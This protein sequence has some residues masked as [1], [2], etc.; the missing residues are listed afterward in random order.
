MKI[1]ITEVKCKEMEIPLF[2]K[3]ADRTDCYVMLLEKSFIMVEDRPLTNESFVFPKIEVMDIY[4]LSVYCS[5][6]VI[7]ISEAEFKN[8]YI[9]TSI[10]LEK[11]L[12]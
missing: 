5:N 3:R 10:T 12:N 7:P 1:T 8:A 9:R 4:Y 11:L 2:F 6:G